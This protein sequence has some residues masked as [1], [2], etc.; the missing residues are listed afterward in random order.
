MHLG[1]EAEGCTRCAMDAVATA[2]MPANSAGDMAVREHRVQ[3]C[4]PPLA[5][6]EKCAAIAPE[7]W[8]MGMYGVWAVCLYA[9]CAVSAVWRYKAGV[10]MRGRCIAV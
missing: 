7:G 10:T 4:S 3:M 6:L 8:C 5:R 2:I 9:V 1:I